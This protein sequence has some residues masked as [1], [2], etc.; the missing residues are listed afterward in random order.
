M[1]KGNNEDADRQDFCIDIAASAHK[2]KDLGDF[3]KNW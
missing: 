3:D 2:T 1:K